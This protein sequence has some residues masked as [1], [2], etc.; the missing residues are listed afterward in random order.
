MNIAL[1][2][3]AAG[4]FFVTVDA[5][6]SVVRDGARVIAELRDELEDEFS[7]RVPL[8]WFV[9]FQRTWTESVEHDRPEAYAEPP[10][11]AFDAFA[12]AADALRANRDRGDEIGWHYHAYHYTTRDDLDH[13]TRMAILAAD[14]RACWTALRERHPE[15]AIE[16]FRFGWFFVP[17]YGVY[18]TLRA[19]GITRDASVDPARRGRVTASS[20]HYLEP[21]AE[22]PARIG[23]MACFPFAQTLL[24]HDWEVVPQDLGWSRLDE[25]G[26][27]AGRARLRELLVQAIEATREAGG[28]LATYANVPLGTLGAPAES[29][30]VPDATRGCCA[31]S[32][33][34]RV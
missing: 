17:D 10:A 22:S 1:A 4:P 30:G 9:R 26:A 25:A 14:L 29:A 7:V 6:T 31:S 13:A 11:K 28:T 34:W 21:I 5:E 32:R 12:L 16:S 24:A 2:R 27:V 18:D 20:T 23:P 15:F 33:C 3:P 8:T 19:F